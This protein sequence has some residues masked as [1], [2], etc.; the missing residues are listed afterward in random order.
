MTD[1]PDWTAQVHALVAAF[2]QEI[3]LPPGKSRP[4]GGRRQ[5]YRGAS[6]DVSG[7]QWN[8]WLFAT[9]EA[10]CAVNLEGLA[11]DGW[12]IARF[13]ERELER[14]R[15][16]DV[17]GRVSAPQLVEVVWYRDAWQIVSRPPIDEKHI[18]LSPRALSEVSHEAW[19]DAL[20]EAY[21]CLDAGKR[22]RGR[23]RQTVTL[24]TTRRQVEKEVSPHLQFRQQL[25]PGADA[26]WADALRVARQNLQPL[27]DWVTEQASPL[28]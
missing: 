22:H 17:R 5:G 27:Y 1:Q 26:G 7:V 9:G 10:Y 11:Y 16:F 6:D 13:I 18:G 8:T 20:R 28:G 19:Q 21:D 3:G 25:T 12:P 2:E 4:F 24:T 15:L 23:A 14:P